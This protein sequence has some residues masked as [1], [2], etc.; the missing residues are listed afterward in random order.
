[1]NRPKKEIKCWIC[2]KFDENSR[3]H[4]IKKTNLK[5]LREPTSKKPL[6]LTN[7]ERKYKVKGRDGNCLKPKAP[8]CPF[9]NNTRTQSSDEAWDKLSAFF[10]DKKMIKAGQT[11]N[12]GKVFKG[13]VRHNML[14]VHLYFIK[15]F[16]CAVVEYGLS[17]IDIS[18][19]STAI[20]N[21][22]SHPNIYIAFTNV[23]KSFP[24]LLGY[25][26]L[27]IDRHT[28]T[29]N[30]ICAGMFIQYGNFAVRILFSDETEIRAGL[31]SSWHR[32]NIN[33]I[34]KITQF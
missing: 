29:G 20:M 9:C 34:L 33:K 4:K 8:M 25:S 22:T 14:L 26:N 19:F 5:I 16:G 24:I 12:L 28:I 23:P 2:G 13:S 7:F 30:I 18:D 1:M 15:L 31:L 32:T 17:G 6:L 27:E 11:I 21:K 3:E 10:E